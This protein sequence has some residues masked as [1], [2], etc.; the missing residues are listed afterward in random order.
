MLKN[1]RRAIYGALVMIG[2]V[3]LA[4]GTITVMSTLTFKESTGVA[5][6]AYLVWVLFELGK[7]IED[8][9]RDTH[10]P[11]ATYDASTIRAL[12]ARIADLESRVSAPDD[13]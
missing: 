8:V 3:L 5:M 4:A 10:E 13:H 11:L 6:T 7:V 9:V 12:D 1:W 2:T